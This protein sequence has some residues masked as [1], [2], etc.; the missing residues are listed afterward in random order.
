M[1]VVVAVAVVEQAGFLVLVF[2]GEAEGEI[3]PFPDDAV[4]ERVVFPAGHDRAA[5]LVEPGGDVA[6]AIVAG[7]EGSIA[8]G[9]GAQTSHA[10]RSLFRSREIQPQGVGAID[11]EGGAAEEIVFHKEVPAVVGEAEVLIGRRSGGGAV[12]DLLAHAATHPIVAE[13]QLAVGH[14][15]GLGRSGG[16]HDG[17]AVLAVP[18]V[19]PAAVVGQAAVGVVG[20]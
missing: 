18:C 12:V 7:G 9:N 8:G 11:S 6:I 19:N 1:R 20:G 2:G 5:V 17:K 3:H 10:A 16:G 13:D 4:A 15:G 14:A